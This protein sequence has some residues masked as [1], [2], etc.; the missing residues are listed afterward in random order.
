MTQHSGSFQLPAEAGAACETAVVN[1]QYQQKRV[2]KGLSNKQG[3][4]QK[5][6]SDISPREIK[7]TIISG[8]YICPAYVISGDV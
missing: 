3:E 2:L 1:P 5:V 4:E 8:F 6:K 7:L